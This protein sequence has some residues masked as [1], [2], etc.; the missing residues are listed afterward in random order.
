MS[1]PTST[2]RGNGQ[3]RVIDEADLA[4]RCREWDQQQHYYGRQRHRDT[5]TQDTGHRTQWT[6][7]TC[8]T[9]SEG[10]CPESGGP[11]TCVTLP[12]YLVAVA[13]S[14]A[15]KPLPAAASRYHLVGL[16][17]SWASA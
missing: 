13:R 11:D 2:Y 16:R 17:A 7:D 5:E 12:E 15:S 6:Q 8:P 9:P 10:V 4:R 1:I 3:S 14:A